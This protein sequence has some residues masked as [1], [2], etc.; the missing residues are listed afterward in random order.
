MKT[1]EEKWLDCASRARSKSL[2]SEEMPFGLANRVIDQLRKTEMSPRTGDALWL[3]LSLRT[4][5]AM[6]TILLLFAFVQ[7]NTQSDSQPLRPAIEVSVVDYS[8][9]L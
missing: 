4:L 2:E 1:F 7:W 9:L 5:F 8:R 3:R 6:S